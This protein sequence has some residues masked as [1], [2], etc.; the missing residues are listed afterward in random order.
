[1]INERDSVTN[2]FTVVDIQGHGAIRNDTT[3]PIHVFSSEPSVKGLDIDGRVTT[4]LDAEFDWK[5]APGEP[6]PA[7]IT[8]QP[9]PTLSYVVT[10][11]G[12]SSSTLRKTKAWYVDPKDSVE[13]YSDF[14]TYVDCPAAPVAAISGGPGITN[15]YVPRGQ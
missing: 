14:R 9:G 10:E 11:Q 15:T 2:V 4:Y 7:Q 6:R 5:P 8:L 13:G 1:M 3:A 12:L